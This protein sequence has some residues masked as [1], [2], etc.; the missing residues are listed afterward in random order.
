MKD[1]KKV[2]DGYGSVYL[3]SYWSGTPTPEPIEKKSIINKIKS[4]FK[5]NER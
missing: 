2:P 1:K 3:N 4:I 5:S